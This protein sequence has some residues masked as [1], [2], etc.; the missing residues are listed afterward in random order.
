[1]A[2]A[3]AFWRSEPVNSVSFGPWVIVAGLP[4]APAGGAPGMPADGGAVVCDPCDVLVVELVAADAMPAA[5]RLA[6]ATTA[7]VTRARRTLP[8]LVDM[9]SSS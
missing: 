1:V 6:P 9:V 8:G 4:V 3:V 5:P 2:A 7:P